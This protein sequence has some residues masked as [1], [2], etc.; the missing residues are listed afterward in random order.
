MNPS[1]LLLTREGIV[2][3]RAVINDFWCDIIPKKGVRIFW[4]PGNNIITNRTLL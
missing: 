2:N 4:I 3:N 1:I